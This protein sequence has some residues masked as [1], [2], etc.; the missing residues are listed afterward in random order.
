MTNDEKL[1]KIKANRD[2]MFQVLCTATGRALEVTPFN[3]GEIIAGAALF[4]CSN[5]KVAQKENPN[6]H[7]AVLQ[8][9]IDLFD[10]ENMK[11]NEE[12]PN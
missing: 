7:V 3:M 10:A 8:Y 4:L 5:V 12:E 6:M 2:K 1:D 11:L 9:M